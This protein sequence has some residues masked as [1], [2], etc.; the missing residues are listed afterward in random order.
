MEIPEDDDRTAIALTH[1]VRYVSRTLQQAVSKELARHRLLPNEFD[2][3]LRLADAPRGRLRT[4]DLVSLPMITMS[5]ASRIVDRLAVQGLVVRSTNV[6][7]RRVTEV[8][9]TQDGRR[10]LAAAR[11]AH[12]TALERVL[13]DAGLDVAAVLPV[14]AGLLTAPATSSR[15]HV[16]ET[17]LGTPVS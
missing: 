16:A 11:S 15:P 17:A 10:R 5:G 1:R 13:A 3:L 12:R 7:D 4:G 6:L 8:E 9:I 14:L 2:A